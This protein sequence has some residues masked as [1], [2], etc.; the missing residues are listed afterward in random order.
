MPTVHRPA[1]HSPGGWASLSRS[2]Q[3][4]T[5]LLL[6]SLGGV[7]KPLG[8]FG[9]QAP[10]GAPPS[11]L[12]ATPQHRASCDQSLMRPSP[13]PLVLVAGTA[14]LPPHLEAAR[15]ALG[16][17]QIP[18]CAPR[19]SRE[20]NSSWPEAVRICAPWG[21]AGSSG[22]DGHRDRTGLVLEPPGFIVPTRLCHQVSRYENAGAPRETSTEKPRRTQRRGTGGRQV[23][24]G[25]SP[26]GL[27]SP[28]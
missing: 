3:H 1:A 9:V 24:L 12:K 15:P 26:L 4:P 14:S 8:H 19:G 17:P 28:Q 21:W 16:G 2:R 25:P 5:H 6:C 23:G 7:A 10:S 27:T 22:C 20:R 18:S 13:R 11:S